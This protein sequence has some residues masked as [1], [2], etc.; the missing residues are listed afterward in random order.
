MRRY[1]ATFG[2][3]AAT[4]YDLTHNLPAGLEVACVVR[5]A[6]TDEDVLVNIRRFSTTTV[7]VNL[8]SAP[9]LNSLKAIITGS[10]A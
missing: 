9:P 1:I 5:L 3:G 4:Q 6:S 10:A 8:A 2:D 7:R